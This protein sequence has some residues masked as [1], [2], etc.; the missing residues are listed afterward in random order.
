MA[1]E[2]LNPGEHKTPDHVYQHDL[3]S[4]LYVLIWICMTYECPGI[5]KKDTK[6]LVVMLWNDS[7]IEKALLGANKHGQLLSAKLIF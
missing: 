5:W 2:I 7:M 6:A 3:E 1:I 4:F